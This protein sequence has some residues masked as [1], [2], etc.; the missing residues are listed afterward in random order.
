MSARNKVND[1]L[2]CDPESERIA[3][4]EVECDARKLFPTNIRND[5]C[6]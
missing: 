5:Y 4:A 1:K 2:S 3:V 6:L